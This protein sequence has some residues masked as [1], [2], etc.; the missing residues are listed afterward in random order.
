MC[1]WHDWALSSMQLSSV[2]MLHA[3][4]TWQVW[5][6]HTLLYWKRYSDEIVRFLLLAA[7]SSTTQTMMI[8]TGKSAAKVV[9]GLLS[10]NAIAMWLWSCAIVLEHNWG[11]LQVSLS[12]DTIICN[13]QTLIATSFTN[14]QCR[15]GKEPSIVQQFL[16]YSVWS[17][18]LTLFVFVTWVLI[19]CSTVARQ[20]AAAW[21]PYVN[22][23]RLQWMHQ[24]A[25]QIALP[26][27]ITVMLTYI[28]YVATNPISTFIN[29]DA[30]HHLGRAY[31]GNSYASNAFVLYLY[32]ILMNV[33]DWTVHYLSGP[34]LVFLWWSGES[35][36]IASSWKWMIPWS[37][38][39]VCLLSFVMAISQLY[40]GVALYCGSMWFILSLFTGINLLFHVVF[41]VVSWA[42]AQKQQ[43]RKNLRVERLEVDPC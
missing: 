7:N 5:G 32:L 14:L 17:F 15:A 37:T 39:F 12:S 27:V 38:I 33:Q 26:H 19:G 1:A 6:D 2:G 3:V 8:I 9:F 22:A 28:Y 18:W 25:F 41:V 34:F 29:Q 24:I 20:E 42:L 10:I 35:R 31:L 40:W 11:C 16:F 23:E 13:E 30:C 21:T 43:I 36:F 4:L